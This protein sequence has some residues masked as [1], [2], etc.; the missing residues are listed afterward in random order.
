MSAFVLP[1]AAEQNTL[2]GA[3]LHLLMS[4]AC[5]H[6]TAGTLVQTVRCL[7]LHCMHCAAYTLTG[8][9]QGLL[10]SQQILGVWVLYTLG[11]TLRYTKPSNSFW[12]F[13]FGDVS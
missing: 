3:A 8:L 2:E 11:R 9:P 4:S 5:S 13:W 1:A 6:L 7:H 10:A 12:G